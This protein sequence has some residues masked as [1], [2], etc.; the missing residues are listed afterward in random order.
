ME[1]EVEEE[2]VGFGDVSEVENREEV[3]EE[4]EEREE[5]DE[6]FEI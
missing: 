2:S 4:I 6:Y 3:E 1:E 5:F